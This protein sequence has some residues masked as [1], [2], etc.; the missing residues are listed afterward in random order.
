[1]AG[2]GRDRNHKKTW[3]EGLA[4]LYIYIYVYRQITFREGKKDGSD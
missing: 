4:L 2:V 1:M 3:R